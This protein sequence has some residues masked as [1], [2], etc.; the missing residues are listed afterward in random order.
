MS[1]ANSWLSRQRKSDLVELAQTVGLK[2]YVS[3]ISLM[4]APCVFFMFS[5][6]VVVSVRDDVLWSSLFGEG[7]VQCVN[8]VK[9]GWER[10]TR[11]LSRSMGTGSHHIVARAR[12]YRRILL[13]SRIL[14]RRRLLQL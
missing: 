3:F 7:G 14:T 13:G 10:S 9:M 1:G 4:L 11:C 12:K 6:R 2:E 8:V 5:C